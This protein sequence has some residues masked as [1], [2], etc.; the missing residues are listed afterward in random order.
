MNLAEEKYLADFRLAGS[1]R[2][3]LIFTPA[4][5]SNQTNKRN[6]TD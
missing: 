1:D 5:T 6:L 2:S 3:E 4:P